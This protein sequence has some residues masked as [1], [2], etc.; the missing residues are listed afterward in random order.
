[1]NQYLVRRSSNRNRALTTALLTAVV[2]ACAG[3]VSGDGET[4]ERADWG[5][6]FSQHRLE[7][8]FV[9][10]EVGADLMEVHN[11]ERATTPR[12]PA[13]TFKIL[14]SMIALETGVV[15]DV[16]EVIPWD[17]VTRE[18]E[19]WN[20]DH[21]LRTGIEVS[22][23]WVYQHLAEQVGEDRMEE[24][25][26]RAEYGNSDIGGGIIDFWLTGDL[27]ISPMEQV[28][29]LHR[30]V[31]EDLPFRPEVIAR[32]RE[33]LV[34]ESGPGWS[35]SHKTGTAL[36]DS[37]ALGW[38]VGITEHRER[39]WVFALNVDLEPNPEVRGEI[40]PSTRVDLARDLLRS[41]G[42]LP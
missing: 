31:T 11:P 41:A 10:Q 3:I 28:E 12:L 33:I 2:A 29:F 20:Q 34:R 32:V 24:W 6:V 17:G 25:V 1:M 5:A 27:R 16:D 21:N 35:W 14:N 19:A 39:T 13:S 7:G 26:S 30:F 36:A 18:V 9:L 15:S 8:T 4:V 22:A 42:A 40:T 38:L 37:P 23:V